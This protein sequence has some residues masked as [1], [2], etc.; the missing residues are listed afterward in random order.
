[1]AA[2]SV[3][4]RGSCVVEL[5]QLD[6]PPIQLP[7]PPQPRFLS[8]VLSLSGCGTGI[9]IAHKRAYAQLRL[10]GKVSFAYR[11]PQPPIAAPQEQNADENQI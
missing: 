2:S 9:P 3:G 11:G 7:D 8:P 4:V 10:N 1:M 5:L 6:A